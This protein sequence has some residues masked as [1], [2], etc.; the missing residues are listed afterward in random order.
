M[1]VYRRLHMCGQAWAC[2]R[3]VGGCL[4]AGVRECARRCVRECL[5][6]CAQTCAQERAIPTEL[7]SRC[8]C[9]FLSRDSGR[10]TLQA[11]ALI[12]HSLQAWRATGAE[13]QAITTP[14][15]AQKI[16]TKLVLVISK[17]TV[18]FPERRLWQTEAPGSSFHLPRSPAVASHWRQDPNQNVNLKRPENCQNTF[19]GQ[20][21]LPVTFPEPRLWQM[22]GPGSSFHLPKYPAVKSH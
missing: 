9:V 5:G 22:E 21:Q 13:I 16:P 4:R 17:C 1:T 14:Y 15:N 11:P 3:A 12:C 8:L 2:V 20:L 18:R 7:V 6:A 19:F 10:L